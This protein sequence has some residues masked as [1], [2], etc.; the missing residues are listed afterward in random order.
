MKLGR[1]QVAEN[2]RAAIGGWANPVGA[3]VLARMSDDPA[4]SDDP[5][6][7]ARAW[8]GRDEGS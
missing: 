2:R 6:T 5:L 4:L 3:L 7:E 8:L 1:G